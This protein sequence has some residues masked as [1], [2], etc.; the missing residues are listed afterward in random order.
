MSPFFTSMGRMF[1]AVLVAQRTLVDEQLMVNLHHED[2]LFDGFVHLFVRRLEDE[3]LSVLFYTDRVRFLFGNQ[4]F[5]GFPLAGLVFG[6]LLQNLVCDST[7]CEKPHSSE[8]INNVFCL[9]LSFLFTRL[10]C[11]WRV[12]DRVCRS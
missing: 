1:A 2:I 11:A 7:V 8:T 3:V 6:K 5:V 9:I 12:P 10:R 4:L